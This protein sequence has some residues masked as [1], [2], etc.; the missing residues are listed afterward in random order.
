MKALFSTLEDVV[1]HTEKLDAEWREFAQ[2]LATRLRRLRLAASLS[3]EDVAYRAGL[4]RFIYQQYEKGES[5]LGTPSNPTLRS[6]LAIAQVFG[7]S[8]DELLPH[9]VPDLSGR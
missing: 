6:V 3:Q 7:V 5:R 9:P 4:S 2:A 1:K 8:V